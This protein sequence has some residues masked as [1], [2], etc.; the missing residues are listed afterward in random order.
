MEP[1]HLQNAV[2]LLA[3]PKLLGLDEGLL[4]DE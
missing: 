1:K 4:Y 3:V 2:K